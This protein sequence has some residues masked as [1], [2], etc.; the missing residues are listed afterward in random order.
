M[1]KQHTLTSE[2]FAGNNIPCVLLTDKGI[3]HEGSHLSNAAESPHSCVVDHID[4]MPGSAEPRRFGADCKISA[5]IFS[6]RVRMQDPPFD[7]DRAAQ[8]DFRPFPGK[9]FKILFFFCADRIEIDLLYP[10]A[11]FEQQSREPDGTLQGD[12]V[13]CDRRIP[14]P[15]F[16]VRQRSFAG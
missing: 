6:Q 16:E 8:K 10:D 13:Q 9:F 12:R 15:R 14:D 3:F 7:A 4:K 11:V 1:S 2:A 5:V